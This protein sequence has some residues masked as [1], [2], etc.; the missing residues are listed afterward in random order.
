MTKDEAIAKIWH[1]I[2]SIR[3]C[4]GMKEQVEALNM[5]IE[6]LK[7]EKVIDEELNDRFSMTKLEAYKRL[8]GVIDSSFTQ[9]KKAKMIGAM[10]LKQPCENCEKVREAYTNGFD[11]GVKDWFAA[12]TQL[13]DA[14][15]REAVIEAIKNY[16]TKLWEKYYEPFPESTVLELIQG[17]PSVQPEC[18]PLDKDRKC[19]C[20]FC[21]ERPKGEWMVTEL[22]CDG[23]ATIMCNCCGNEIKISPRRF[24]Q[25]SSCEKFCSLCGAEMKGVQK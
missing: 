25:L 10:A 4:V 1:E 2:V 17:L 6:A 9:M 18:P 12:K 3:E 14:V 19:H 24:E 11:Y 7:A 15:S 21:P 16:A 13:C 20:G 5:A 23:G 8:T 22:F